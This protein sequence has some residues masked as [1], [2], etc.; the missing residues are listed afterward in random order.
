M[1]VLLTGRSVRETVGLERNRSVFAHLHENDE[2]RF[3]SHLRMHEF[4]DRVVGDPSVPLDE[5]VRCA[6][7]IGAVIAVVLG[8]HEGFADVSADEL[9]PVVLDALRDLLR[10]DH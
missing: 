5:R 8:M 4:V 7:S 9:R 10:V 3:A 2:G 1:V 6:C